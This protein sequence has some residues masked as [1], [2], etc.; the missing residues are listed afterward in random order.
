MAIYTESDLS[1]A[2]AAH[3]KLIQGENIVQFSCGNKFFTFGNGNI[4][5]LE[6]LIQKIELD[7]GQFV[8]RTY[9]KQ[10]RRAS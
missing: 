4:Q 2:R 3:L 10:G 7:L 5:K 6:D 1:S 9:A 8:G